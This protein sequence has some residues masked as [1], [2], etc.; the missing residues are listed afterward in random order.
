[1]YSVVCRGIL[2]IKIVRPVR[3]I[4]SIR[5]ALLECL[6]FREL[7]ESVELP[8]NSETRLPSRIE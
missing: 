1:M 4:F 7:D 6:D 2:G 3:L 5:V 8:A